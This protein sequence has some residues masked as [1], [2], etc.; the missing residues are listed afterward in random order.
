M[1]KNLYRMEHRQKG[2]RE[3]PEHGEH[4]TNQGLAIVS[5]GA[6]HLQIIDLASCKIYARGS[7]NKSEHYIPS[8]LA[9][10]AHSRVEK[11][12][13]PPRYLLLLGATTHVLTKPGVINSHQVSLF[14]KAHFEKS[15]L[16]PLRHPGLTAAK[17]AETWHCLVRS[18]SSG[19]SMHFIGVSPNP[20]FF[21]IFILKWA[22]N[23]F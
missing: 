9:S 8:D 15:T 16:P 19:N 18:D 22:V 6:L 20:L 5:L 13:E 3:A 23:K 2:M 1:S 10:V 11:F 7:K 4:L 14:K 12:S 21:S 17:V